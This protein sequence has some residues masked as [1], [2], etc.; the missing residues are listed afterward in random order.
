MASRCSP[1]RPPDGS[2]R[3]C[4]VFP[5]APRCSWHPRVPDRQASLRPASRPLTTSSK[6]LAAHRQLRWQPPPD[7]AVVLRLA[8]L[9]QLTRV[10]ESVLVPGRPATS[11]GLMASA[12][13]PALTGVAAG[14]GCAETGHVHGREPNA[15]AVPR[16]GASLVQKSASLAPAPVA[17]A[18][19]ARVVGVPLVVPHW[20]VAPAM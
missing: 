20:A 10:S 4:R 5:M 6:S 18:P 12:Q 19:V 11:K 1:R 15:P 17:G 14:D 7:R 16:V 8:M 13:E 2:P 9:N 3:I